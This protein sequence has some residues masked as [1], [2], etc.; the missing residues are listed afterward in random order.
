LNHIELSVDSGAVVTAGAVDMVWLVVPGEKAVWTRASEKTIAP[1]F[2]S[3]EIV[4]S[5]TATQSI[6]ATPPIEAIIP[7]STV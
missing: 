7:P 6:L 5:C 2:A 3:H 1:T 4:G